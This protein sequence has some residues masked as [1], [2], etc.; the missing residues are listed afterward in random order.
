M[1]GS[2]PVHGV[3]VKLAKLPVHGEDVHVVVLLEVQ[4]QQVQGVVTSLQPLLILIDLL[5]LNMEHNMFSEH[6]RHLCRHL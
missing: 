1:Y 3:L 4:G 5:H 6:R 2:I